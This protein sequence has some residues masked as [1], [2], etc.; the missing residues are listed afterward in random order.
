VKQN[1]NE[2]GKQKKQSKISE[3]KLKLNEGKTASIFLL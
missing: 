2:T 3:K 1:E